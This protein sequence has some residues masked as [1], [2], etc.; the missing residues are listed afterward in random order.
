MAPL[1]RF[2]T[3]LSASRL[4]SGI[5]ASEI[6][7][8][9]QDPCATIGGKE[10]VAP[11]DVRACFLSFKVDP[12]TKSNV[13][14][15]LPPRPPPLMI[16]QIL[17]VVSKTL[18]FHTSVNY[19]IRAPE[20]FTADVHE[21]IFADLARISETQYSSDYDLHIDLSRSVKRLNDG[22]CVWI[23]ACYARDL[24]IQF[25]MFPDR[26]ISYKGL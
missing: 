4:I 26:T 13:R 20:P 11:K 7:T 6:Q 16:T 23:N 24:I 15:V 8:R 14:A 25:V 1:Y 2:L 17:D 3:L 12:V 22:H 5:A 19:E 9:E 10:W 18:A 21:D